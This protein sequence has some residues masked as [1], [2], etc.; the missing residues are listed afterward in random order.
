M[1]AGCMGHKLKMYYTTLMTELFYLLQKKRHKNIY[2]EIGTII[3][4]TKNSLVG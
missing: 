3:K 4:A 2:Q 1:H